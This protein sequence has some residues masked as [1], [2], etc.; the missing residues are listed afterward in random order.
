MSS[1]RSTTSA[2]EHPVQHDLGEQGV[3]QGP[4][5]LDAVQAALL[6]DRVR[7]VQ[8]QAVE[9]VDHQHPIGTQWS[10]YGGDGDPVVA[11]GARSIGIRELADGFAEALREELDFTVEARNLTTVIAARRTPRRPGRRARR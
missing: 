1:G 6:D 7:P 9:E 2:K 10:V 5:Q 11:A 3:Q 4:R 8:R